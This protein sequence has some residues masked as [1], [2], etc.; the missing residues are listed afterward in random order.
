[1]TS[2]EIEL[3][4]RRDAAFFEDWSEWESLDDLPVADKGF[5]YHVQ[6]PIDHN[7]YW[8]VLRHRSGRIGGPAFELA[9]PESYPISRM[10]Q[11]LPGVR[12]MPGRFHGSPGN[13]LVPAEH[14]QQLRKILPALKT[15][16]REYARTPR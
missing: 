16:C 12:R 13:Y 7:L 14:W 9:L 2:P 6:W 5:G 10:I 8:C 11:A 15:A 1:M 4:R 3:Q